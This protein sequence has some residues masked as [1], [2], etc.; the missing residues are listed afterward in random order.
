MIKKY[1]DDLDVIDNK[2]VS[3]LEERLDL[4]VKIGEYK[5][6]NGLDIYDPKREEEVIERLGKLVK[7]NEYKIN[8]S[9][10]FQ[11]IMINSKDLQ[12]KKNLQK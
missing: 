7:N 8:I 2:L 10:I 3:L 5:K 12:N 4:C 9:D 6:E 11:H 1:R